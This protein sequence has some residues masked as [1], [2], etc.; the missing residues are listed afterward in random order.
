LL[1]FS[2]AGALVGL[3]DSEV[4]S[5]LSAPAIDELLRDAVYE[6]LNVASSALAAEGRA[7]LTKM[8]TNRSEV[9]DAFETILAK[10]IRR[11]DFNVS[12]DDYEGGKFTVLS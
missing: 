8:V 11:I 9:G 1:L 6:V 12:V 3:P 7:V 5:R 2:C 4:Q 10:P